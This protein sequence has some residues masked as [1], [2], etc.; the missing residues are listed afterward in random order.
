MNSNHHICTLEAHKT[1]KIQVLARKMMILRSNFAIFE[2]SGSRSVIGPQRQRLVTVISSDDWVVYFWTAHEKKFPGSLL[3]SYRNQ[4]R[5]HIINRCPLERFPRYHEL[6]N[7]QFPRSGSPKMQGQAVPSAPS[8]PP[9]AP[10]MQSQP[11]PMP[12]QAQ[13]KVWVLLRSINVRRSIV[14]KLS[15]IPRISTLI[16]NL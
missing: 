14:H 6:Y 13:P 9:A 11:Q 1:L 8:A 12:A 16:F 3:T 10:V 4:P 2:T 5:V 15:N 7:S